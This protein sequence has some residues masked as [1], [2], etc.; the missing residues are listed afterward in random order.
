MHS[1]VLSPLLFISV[2]HLILKVHN[3]DAMSGALFVALSVYLYFFMTPFR[4]E[5]F[6][7]KHSIVQLTQFSGKHSITS[8][9]VVVVVVVVVP[10]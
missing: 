7:A 1:V 10:P 8:A 5:M 6:L 2:N 3:S 4:K 9:V